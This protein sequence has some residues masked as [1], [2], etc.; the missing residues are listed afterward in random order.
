MHRILLKMDMQL[1]KQE[2]CIFFF[3]VLPAVHLSIFILVINQLG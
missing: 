1:V 2:L 3:Y